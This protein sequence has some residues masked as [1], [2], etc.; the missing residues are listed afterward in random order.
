MSADAIATPAYPREGCPACK[1]P[2]EMTVL[3]CDLDEEHERWTCLDTDCGEDEI[4]EDDLARVEN[5]GQYLGT[6]ALDPARVLKAG[7]VMPSMVEWVKARV[8]A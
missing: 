8:K 5:E 1:G 2:V 7:K 3:T 6:D 4:R